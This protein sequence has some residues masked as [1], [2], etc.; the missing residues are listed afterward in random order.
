MVDYNKLQ[1]HIVIP[2]ETTKK[3]VI[4]QRITVLK[5]GKEQSGIKNKLQ[6][7]QKTWQKRKKK[8]S[9]IRCAK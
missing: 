1:K 3:I 7:V 2:S 8:W 9:K 5:K 6:L 4:K